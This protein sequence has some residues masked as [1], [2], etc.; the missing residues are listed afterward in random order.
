MKFTFSALKDGVRRV[1][2]LWVGRYAKPHVVTI[3]DRPLRPIHLNERT[4]NA[5]DSRITCCAGAAAQQ[6]EKLAVDG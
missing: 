1:A 2:V 4:H 5:I 3:N 6:Q